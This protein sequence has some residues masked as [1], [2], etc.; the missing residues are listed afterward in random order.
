MTGSSIMSRGW[1]K[2]I[3]RMAGNPMENDRIS[4]FLFYR[5]MRPMK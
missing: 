1:G 4:R 2:R 5:K 3:R